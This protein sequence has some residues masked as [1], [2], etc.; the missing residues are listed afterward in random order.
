MSLPR[1]SMSHRFEEA[2]SPVPTAKDVPTHGERQHL[3]K[4]ADISAGN[5]AMKLPIDRPG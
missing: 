3:G 4:S 1:L 5:A 2:Q